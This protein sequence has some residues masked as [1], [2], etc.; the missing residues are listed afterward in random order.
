MIKTM[1]KKAQ[2][3]AL[4]IAIA[5]GL[6]IGGLVLGLFGGGAGLGGL[7]NLGG[8]EGAS[9]SAAVDLAS[10]D[11]ISSVTMTYN[12]VD[13]ELAGVD[14][15]SNLRIIT[16]NLGQVVDDGT[17]ALTP[18][19]H[20]TGL[21][22]NGST[23][24]YTKFV[25]WDTGC[26]NFVLKENG[27]S[28]VQLAN[29][30]S[31]TTVVKNSENGNSNSAADR[32]DLGQDESDVEVTLKYD[33]NSNNYWGN[34]N[35]VPALNFVTCQYDRS[36]IINIKVDG[37]ASGSKPTEFAFAVSPAGASGVGGEAYDGDNTFIIPSLADGGFNTLTLLI[38]SV[39]GSDPGDG[40]FTCNFYDANLDLNEEDLT[41]IAGVED[42]DNNEI[43]LTG[44]NVTVH[45]E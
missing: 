12:D 31:I 28:N 33:V 36:D 14:P 37:A 8:D 11:G 29:K 23:T 3:F 43:Y 19:K 10:C 18:K 16:D 7:F 30:P 40:N 34:P 26:S 42:E 13:M 9:D 38:D 5:A 44:F 25:E 32:Q 6:I 39:S 4:A 2:A 35:V 24:Y 17:I 22:G 15:N 1:Y 20:Y 21:A 45:Y 27:D 41:L